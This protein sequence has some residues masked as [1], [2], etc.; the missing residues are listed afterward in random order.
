MSGILVMNKPQGFTSF[1]VIGKLRGILRM[2]RL[3]HTGTLDPMAEGVLPVLVGTAARACDLLPD[4]TKTY[5][6]GFQLGTVTDTQDST[7]RI[8]ETRAASVSE[9]EL[10][11]VFPQFIGE[12]Q[13]IP[14][15]YS[16]VQI[17]GKRLYELAREGKQIERKARTVQVQSLKLLSFQPE[18]GTGTVEIV[19]G[20]GT[21]VRTILH[22][23]GQAL[24]CG[25]MMTAL[26]RTAACGFTLGDAQDF[27]A[28]QQAADENRLTE[29][30]IPTDRL[31]VRYPELYLT[32]KQAQLYRNGVR[33]GLSQ[34]HGLKPDAACCRVYGADGTFFGLA[35]PDSA[36]DCLRIVKNL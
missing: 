16:A 13:Q 21:Y 20:K 31:F 27:A 6:A 32:E 30:L 15:M 10:L 34:L 33:L 24:Q 29:L 2:R 8:L 7:G 17:N 25:A 23:I 9:A 36:A 12:I 18:D 3:G 4:E 28:V 11:R 14:P 35:R 1:D 19:C 5:R 22:D 26:L